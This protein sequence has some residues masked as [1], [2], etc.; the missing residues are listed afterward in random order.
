MTDTEEYI[1]RLQDER[2]ALKN[3]LI[4]NGIL[5]DADGWFK[6]KGIQTEPKFVNFDT[7]VDVKLTNGE[8]FKGKIID[9]WGHKENG[10]NIVAYKFS[11]RSD[12]NEH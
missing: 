7:C 10:N 1:I 12:D 11:K 4:D 3:M 9:E 2:D 6:W 8:Y 5:P